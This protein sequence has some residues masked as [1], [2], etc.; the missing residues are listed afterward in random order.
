MI[1]LNR[2]IL[3]RECDAPN[4]YGRRAQLVNETACDHHDNGIKACL[5]KSNAAFRLNA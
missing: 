3:E 2:V 4:S 5:V 1:L